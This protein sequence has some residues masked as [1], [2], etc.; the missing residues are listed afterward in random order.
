MSAV[1][2]EK[3]TPAAVSGA[4]LTVP[5]QPNQISIAVVFSAG[6]LVTLMTSSMIAAALQQIEADLDMP[7]SLVQMAFSIYVLGLAFGPFII[8][9]FSE[10]FG[11]KPAWIASNLWYILWNSLCPVGNSQALLLVGRLM[12][13]F[14]AA[15]GITLTGPVLADMYGAKDRGKS[16]SAATFLPYLGPA[17]GPIVGGLTTQY[18]HWRFLFWVMSGFD[19]LVLVL[20]IIIVRETC[21]PV[22][23]RRLDYPGRL[24][25]GH[26]AEKH[27]SRER[28]QG[29]LL[30]IRTAMLRPIRLLLYRP[31]IIFISVNLAV[32]FAVYYLVLSSYATL[33]EERYNQS[34]TASSLHYIAIA[35]G[36][37]IAAQGGGRMMDW[38]F[39]LQ[40]ARSTN[41]EETPEIRIPFLVAPMVIYPVGTFWIGW[42]A[43]KYSHWAVLDV[44]VVVFTCASFMYSQGFYA[45][46]M[47][48]FTHT[49]SANAAVRMLSNI[50]AFAFPLFAPQLYT[51]LG[52]GWGDSLLGFLLIIICFPSIV[53]LRV[54]GPRLRAFRKDERTS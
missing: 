16:L 28:I 31:I 37:T 29:T 54:Y 34:E 26:E 36:A 21:A 41:G 24:S 13:G 12:A 25:S 10:V 32:D 51:S 39:E 23:L 4:V 20:G 33:F 5:P 1:S 44:G 11:R 17:L 47:D 43:E 8:G 14:G 53:I 27:F 22:L 6:S 49:A 42:A 52:L 35:I 2:S 9:P 15:S 38:M 40:K 46:L 19:A 48:E 3:D 45:Y 50:L 30:S 7:A 18:I